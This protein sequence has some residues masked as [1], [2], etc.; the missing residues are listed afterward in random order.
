M[1]TWLIPLL[2]A[3]AWAGAAG[4]RRADAGPS[5][6]SFRLENGLTVILRPIQGSGQVALV[7]LYGIGGDHDP[8]G[9]SGLAHSVEHVY[10]T[11]GA[12]S[13]R[14]RTAE[15]FFRRYSAGA[16]AQ[17]G[18]RYTVVATV[19]PKEELD[20]ELREAA[21]R[22]GDLRVTAGDFDRERGR[23]LEEVENMF[24][25]FP[26]LGAVNNARELVRPT[27][28]GGRK[29]GL[30][31]HIRAIT[32]EDVREHWSRYYKPR[33]ATLV[34]AGALDA[35][36]ARR[37]IKEHFA[38]LAAGEEVPT[39]PSPGAAKF[40]TI[41]E[42]VVTPLQPGAASE[43]C[44]AYAAP[45]PGSDLYA[46]FLV[47][48]ARLW[49]NSAKFGAGPGRFPIYF[50]VLEDPAVVGVSATAKAGET[51]AQAVARL[52]AS[53][54]E[55]LGPGLREGEPV[56]A[57]QAFA[58]LLGTADIPDS[59]LAQNPYG[60]AL[61]LAQRRQLGIDPAGLKRALGSVTD[62]DLRRA[63]KEVFAPSRHAGAFL[64]VGAK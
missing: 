24:G 44:L 10:V 25:R 54:A 4:C 26:S 5:P 20:A 14:P 40:G 7:V 1:R 56:A 55:V 38:G 51:A 58:L 49:S 19:F 47:L 64:S 61:A 53:V 39:P 37:A 42:L 63:A 3:A 41:R 9:R 52:E 36:A 17:T 13:V 28:R 11:A 15:E 23:L 2:L 27:P 48:V 35:A 32:T 6:E 30:P 21:A 22:M 29:G 31:E 8:Q 50:P 46:P 62:A 43:V 34:L 18:D 16:N 45:E 60:V 57:Q 59:L 33:N 12:G